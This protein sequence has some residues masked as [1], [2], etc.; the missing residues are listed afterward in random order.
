VWAGVP[1]GAVSCPVLVVHGDEDAEMPLR[2]ARRLLALIDGA[3]L[4]VL[5]GA[6]HKCMDDRPERFAE[7]VT[8]FLAEGRAEA[9][10]RGRQAYARP[11]PSWYWLCARD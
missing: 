8:A 9:G 10:A 6:S 4:E 3:R 5:A 1:H 2:H 11:S 7:V